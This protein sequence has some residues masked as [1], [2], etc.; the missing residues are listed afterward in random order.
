MMPHHCHATGCLVKV[1]PNKLM[2]LKHWDMVHPILQGLIQERYVKGQEISKRPSRE[3]LEAATMSVGYVT[4][5]TTGRI[6]MI[7][8]KKLGEVGIVIHT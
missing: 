1:P 2:C 4:Y 7:L 3:Y 6:N 5:V 8:V